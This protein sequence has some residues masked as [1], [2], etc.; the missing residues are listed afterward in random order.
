MNRAVLA[1]VTAAAVIAAA[2]G[3]LIGVRGHLHSN[4]AS[5]LAL[6]SFAAAQTGGDPI[7]F[8]DPDGHRLQ[9]MVRK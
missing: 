8:Q 4:D 6:V 7:Y 9:L 2:G 1:G 3:G 5:K